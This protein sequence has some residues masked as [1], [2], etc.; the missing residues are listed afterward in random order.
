MKFSINKNNLILYLILFCMILPTIR[1]FNFEM[2]VV[3][4]LSPIG[5][6]ILICVLFGLVKVPSITKMI[7]FL[8]LM[9]LIQIIISTFYSTIN[10]LGYFV[11]PTDIFQY[12]VRFVFLI[13]FI[14]LAYKGRINKEKFIKCFLIVLIFGMGIGVL[15]WI[16]WPGREFFIK[17]YPFRDGLEQI[18]QL[19]RPLYSLRL[20]GFAQHATANG[21]SASFAIAFAYSVRRYYGKYNKLSLILLILSIINIIASQARAGMLAV[22]FSVFLFY[23]I[24]IKYERKGFKPTVYFIGIIIGFSIIMVYLYNTGNTFVIRNF[25]RWIQLFETGGGARATTQPQYFF[26]IMK[27]TDYFFGLSKPIVNRSAISYGV[28]VELIN[29]LVTYGITGFLLQYLLIAI[30]LVY[31]YK[32]ISKRTQDKATLALCIASFVGLFGYQVFSVAYYFFREIRIGLFPW[33]LMGVTIG[34]YERYKRINNYD[35]AY[36]IGG[37]NFNGKN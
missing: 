21:G 1:F 20:H 27:G 26:S 34:V 12:V 7:I 29:I 11:F 28:E 31:F 15:Q 24:N 30:L 33:V 13:S 10:K 18:S 23:V 14:V 37:D 3:Y 5:I 35:N 6:M 16:P 2:P 22:A 9:I 32:K 8:W 4:L 25:D 36:F 17:M 19:S